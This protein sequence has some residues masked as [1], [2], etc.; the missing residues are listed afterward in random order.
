MSGPGRV[1]NLDL[2]KPG[3]VRNPKG[4]NG[5][6]YRDDAERCL[7][8]WCKENGDTLIERLLDDAANGKGW[9]MKLALDRILPAVQ[10]HEVST[11]GADEAALDA[12]LVRLAPKAKT[13]GDARGNGSSGP[14]GDERGAA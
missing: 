1:E 5:F 6:S 11:P 12:L 7:A 9:A 14:A 3:E 8:K 10:K 4:I 2:I 13:N